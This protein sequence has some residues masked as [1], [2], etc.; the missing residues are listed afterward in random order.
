[1]Q[2]TQSLLPYTSLTTKD[3]CY[4]WTFGFQSV[5]QSVVQFSNALKADVMLK[6]SCEMLSR[7]CGL[8]IFSKVM[9]IEITEGEHGSCVA[10]EKEGGLQNE[11]G[12]FWK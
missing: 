5:P 7:F 6:A 11:N 2:K 8:Y 10:G 1:M 4:D 9:R 3:Q 12:T